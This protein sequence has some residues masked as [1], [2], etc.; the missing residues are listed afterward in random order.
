[1]FKDI[2]SFFQEKQKTTDPIEV[3]TILF[4]YS[5]L[6]YKESGGRDYFFLQKIRN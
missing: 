4:P 6:L 3:L 1:M 2:R 5:E